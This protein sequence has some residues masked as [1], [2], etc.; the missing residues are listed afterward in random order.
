MQLPAIAPRA[1]KAT[2]AKFRCNIALWPALEEVLR[3]VRQIV[4]AAEAQD[5]G[6][7]GP[8]VVRP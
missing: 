2:E 5:C 7:L 1:F 4:A 3:L 6:T 8:E